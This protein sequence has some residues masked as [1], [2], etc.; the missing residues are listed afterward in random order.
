MYLK[1][2]K[3]DGFKSFANKISLHLNQNLT[4]IVGPNGAGKSNIVDAVRWVLGEQSIKSL[5]GQEL[6]SD[7]IFSGSKSRKAASYAAVTL[8][9]D[10][11]DY[12]LN[13]DYSE[14]AIKRIVYQSGEN[15]YYLNNQRC[16][17]KDITNL[18]I[19]T[20]LTKESYNII[21]Q[22]QIQAIISDKPSERR[23][24]IEEVAG[25]LKYKKRKERAL[26]KLAKTHDNIKR[27]NDIMIELN[28]QLE[29]LKEQQIKANQY[30]VLKD[31]LK[32]LEISLI[33]EEINTLNN[34]YQLSK[35]NRERLNE[36][37]LK[38]KNE[39][40][41]YQAE[42]EKEKL[43]F[44][45]DNELLHKKEQELITLSS[46][47]EKI[48]GQKNL[49]NERKQYQGDNP[50]LHLQQLLLK[51]Q[52][53]KIDNDISLFKSSINDKE[54]ALNEL[55][56]K[57]KEQQ[58]ILIKKGQ[59]K[60]ELKEK[61][62]NITKQKIELKYKHDL[63]EQSIEQ[64]NNLSYAVKA[65][66]NNPKLKGL[67][68]AIGNLIKVEDDYINA[69]DIA[70][71]GSN[72]FIVVDNENRAKEAITYLKNNQLGRATF[73][74]LNIIKPKK[75]D[76]DIY[77]LIKNYPNY[78]DLASNLVTYKS[79]Y[80]NII[81]NRLG[82]VIVTDNIKSANELAKIINYRYKIVTL[83]GAL[84]HIGGSITGG[85]QRSRHTLLN[86]RYLLKE[87]QTLFNN[88]EEEI[89]YLQTKLNDL[90]I[91]LKEQTQKEATIKNEIIAIEQ[92]IIH[93]ENLL[94]EYHLKRDD[95][96]LQLKGI[97]GVLNQ[98]LDQQEKDIVN[99]YYQAVSHKNKL[100][101][102]IEL[103]TNKIKKQKDE[104]TNLEEN[105]KDKALSLKTKEQTL[106]NLEIRINRLDV[107]LDNLLNQL[108]EEY[109]LTFE[110]AK[111]SYFLAINKKEATSK[112][113][114]LKASLNELGI[115]NLG[116][117]EQYEQLN[118]RHKF[119]NEQKN[120]LFNAE[121]TLLDII[122]EMDSTMIK[123]FSN[124]FKSINQHFKLIFKQLFNGGKAELKLTE[125]SS[126]LTTGIDIIALPPGKKIDHLSLL[127]GGEKTLTALALLFAILK[128]RPVPF[129]LLDE[130]EAAL[131][132]VN[133]IGFI[134]FITHF[135]NQTQFIIITHQK[136]TMEY[137]DVLYGITMME[138]GISKLVSVKLEEIKK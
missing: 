58:T 110:K 33:V 36:T 122:K 21:A 132:E 54:K 111:K 80:K 136:K 66:L 65:V 74:P 17:L 88:C 96:N 29:P 52:Q 8:I 95:L 93:K 67:H 3:I 20:G 18:I 60:D 91:N 7:V 77:Q 56:A 92:F 108:N 48:S 109:K 26:L 105:L 10:N 123:L 27:V 90:E 89:K 22:D 68:N 43:N 51:E 134:N 37:I 97:K 79:I 135:K 5:R 126:M 119:L 118:S 133:I 81:L 57:L 107:K 100:L 125:P 128:V 131:D 76:S 46:Q 124:T 83:D 103:L 137:I 71:G 115:V 31:D 127:S 63:L 11:S 49:I 40:I 13:L 130:V 12:Y 41:R 116:A 98:V 99:D 78:I 120:D 104:M 30:L 85:H 15:E 73:F 64:Q 34:D 44:I 4:G 70:L 38:L 28:S 113:N 82:N 23:I 121:N 24:I 102:K 2:I 69:I 75:I 50:K 45:T 129:C 16:R 72:Q 55:K 94:N 47:V 117:I 39:E 6:M 14:V 112:V 32:E 42:L 61:I 86:E 84:L 101:H 62:S 87:K 1:E 114:Q 53:L 106:K 19:D 35:K 25:V 9:F 59:T 138:S